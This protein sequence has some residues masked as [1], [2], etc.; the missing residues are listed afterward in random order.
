MLKAILV[1][2]NPIHLR[3]LNSIIEWNEYGIEVIEK[4]TS[5]QKA[6]DSLK[7]TI[8]D[9]ILTDIKMPDLDGIYLAAEVKNSHPEI[10][11]IFISSYDDFEFAKSAID[12]NISG[13]LLKPLKEEEVSD[14]IFK[15]SK[16]IL[17]RKETAKK[18]IDYGQIKEK[19]RDLYIEQLF[20][21]LINAVDLG[22][23][24]NS[25]LK[26][27]NMDYLADKYF[28][29]LTL[30]LDKNKVSTEDLYIHSNKIND[31]I[32]SDSFKY[33]TP[34]LIQQAISEYICI[35]FF[36]TLN[37]TT[38]IAYDFAI[39]LY[40]EILNET[41]VNILIGIS[42][43]ENDF[44]HI[45]SLCQK[46]KEALNNRF[47][48]N[49]DIIFIY[50]QTD[51][52]IIEKN[53]SYQE[54]YEEINAI[55]YSDDLLII[56]NFVLKH[57]VNSNVPVNYAGQYAKSKLLFIISI[58]EII[59]INE[60]KNYSDIFNDDF[61]VWKKVMQ[62]ESILDIE[63]WL[64]NIFLAIREAITITD[65]EDSLIGKIKQIV[66]KH[67]AE[68]LSAND[69]GNMLFYT[70][71][72]LNYIF[73]KNT[74]ITIS[75]YIVNYRIEISKKLLLTTKMKIGDIS[76]AVGYSSPHHFRMIFTKNTG[77]SP[78]EF[79]K[80]NVSEKRGESSEKE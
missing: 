9:I 30:Q 37:N 65:E 80:I 4:Y 22:E 34:I 33:L 36:D 49:D 27:L 51:A 26:H 61:I 11:I 43:T 8:P 6:L 19:Y 74:G 21:E 53:I 60:Q 12:L 73:K 68:N 78:I 67:Y 50:Q 18:I 41:N 46:S 40:N 5:A 75:E 1:D 54:L 79:K 14:L 66:H 59:L 62:F 39:R 7:V 44:K 23:T 70:A 17:I 56:K 16:E 2:D 31:I 29:I 69:I 58:L 15:I 20:R 48:K 55:V 13:Y 10:S 45:Y 42:P 77:I 64:T 72:Q 28:S 63:Q 3:Q 57:F 76:E 32:H 52:P 35:I 47:Y 71:R 25:R 24:L 38:D